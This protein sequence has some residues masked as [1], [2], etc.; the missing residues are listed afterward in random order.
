MCLWGCKFSPLLNHP[1]IAYCVVRTQRNDEKEGV[2]VR[3]LIYGDLRFTKSLTLLS[4][5]KS[6]FSRSA[7]LFHLCILL[8]SA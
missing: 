6:P 4:K 5:K 8:P 7:L 2:G 1:K 3:I